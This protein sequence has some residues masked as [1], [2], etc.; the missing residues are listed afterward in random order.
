MNSIVIALIAV[1][2]W[3]PSGPALA[4][5]TPA[6]LPGVK[7][8]VADEVSRLLSAG[9][10]VVDTR[11]KIEYAES[12][13]KGARNVPYREKSAKSAAFDARQDQFDLTALPAD[14]SA[15]VVFYCNA[16]ECWKSYKASKVALGAGF[17]QVHWFRGGLPEWR[18]K[19]L[20]LE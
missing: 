16:G 20:P 1:I 15:P 5:Q 14:R 6:S 19:G 17:T 3:M 18:D 7:I 9:A 8:V 13:I 10:L 2:A 4:Q 12:H 11:T